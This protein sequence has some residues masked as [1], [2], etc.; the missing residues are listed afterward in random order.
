MSATVLQLD[1]FRAAR[2]VRQK[3][4]HKPRDWAA[5]ARAFDIANPAVWVTF[6][7][8]ALAILEQP[9]CGYM[10]PREPWE[11]TRKTLKRSINNNFQKHYSDRLKLK[12]P[13]HAAKFRTRSRA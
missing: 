10:S 4:A 13:E 6:E 5:E 8:A 12:Y 9:G 7:A 1:L 3:R 11:A 2:P